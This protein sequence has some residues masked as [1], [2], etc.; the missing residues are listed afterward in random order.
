MLLRVAWIALAELPSLVA[1]CRNFHHVGVTSAASG[2][3]GKY[4]QLPANGAKT[5]KAS[6]TNLSAYRY[7]YAFV[8]GAD[9]KRWSTCE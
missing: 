3:L 9:A 1:D 7:V 4:Q 5:S 6:L 8:D 2:R